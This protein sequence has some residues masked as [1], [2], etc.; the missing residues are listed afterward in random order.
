MVFNN[1]ATSGPRWYELRASPGGAFSVYQLGTYA[2]GASGQVDG[3]RGDGPGGRPGTPD[4]AVS[5]STI[6]PAIRYSGRVPT[7]PLGTLDGQASII[8][9]AGSQTNGLHRWGDYSS[10]RIDPSDDCSFWYINEYLASDGAFNWSTRIGSFKFTGLRP[11]LAGF[12]SFRQSQ[13]ADDPTREF[14]YFHYHRRFDIELQQSRHVD[15][16]VRLPRVHHLMS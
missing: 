8:E 5:S 14:Q 6:H 7:D 13:H 12:L 1:S 3:Q 11:G 10:L 15:G 4:T 9:G 16:G 2:P